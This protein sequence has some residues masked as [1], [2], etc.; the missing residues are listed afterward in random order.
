MYTVFLQID[1]EMDMKMRLDDVVG[2]S[3]LGYMAAFSNHH[4]LSTGSF[5]RVYY[6]HCRQVPL[7]ANLEFFGF[8]HR[9]G[10]IILRAV[11]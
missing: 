4:Q 8:A 7:F 11:V 5:N 3:T 10:F 2:P 1:T 9:L 6:A